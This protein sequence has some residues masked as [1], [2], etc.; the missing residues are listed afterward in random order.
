[1]FYVRQQRSGNRPSGSRHSFHLYLMVAS[2]SIFTLIASLF[3]SSA[4]AFAA[5]VALASGAPA[6]QARQTSH[7]QQKPKLSQTPELLASDGAANDQFAA[8]LNLS[9]NGKVGIIGAPFHQVGNNASAG[10]AY[11]YVRNDNGTWSQVAELTASDGAADD[12]FGTS[13]SLSSD[14]S[15]AIVGAPNHQVGNN[16]GAG[17]AYVYTHSGNT[18]TQ[19]AILTATNNAAG[20]AL[21]TGSSLSPDGNTALVGADGRDNGAG[22]AYIF[23]KGT[24]GSWSQISLLTASDSVAN[25]QLGFSA[26]LSG[27][28]STALIGAAATLTTSTTSGAAYIFTKGTSGWSASQTQTA[29]VS[30]S[31][32]ATGD[33]FGFTVS[34]SFNGGVAMVGAIDHQVGNNA[35]AGEAYV[36]TRGTSSNSYSQSAILRSSDQA[37]GDQF[38]YSVSLT[39]DGN[40]ALIGAQGHMVNGNATAGSAYVFKYSN[41]TWNQF[42]EITVY[43]PGTGDNFGNTDGISSDGNYA[44]VG[45]PVHMVGN[46]AAQGDA[47][48]FAL[49]QPTNELIAPDNGAGDQLGAALNLSAD[50]KVAIAGAPFHQ[51]GNNAGAGAAYIYV[52]NSTG[53]FQAAELTAPDGAA[54]DQFGTSVSL[55]GDGST[56]I[57]GA[58][59]H[60]IGSNAGAGATYVFSRGSGNVWTQ[61]A[62]LTASGGQA[63]DGLGIGGSIS[64]DGNTTIVGAAG[65]A[66]NAGAAYVF[67]RSN[68]TWHQIALL[69]AA[70]SIPNNQLGFSV[71]LSGD[72][73]TVIIGASATMT[74][75]TTPGAAYIFTKSGTNS[76]NA[77]ETAMLNPSDGATG[78][79]FGFTVS[80]SFNG[81]VA[82]VGAI[83][84]QV[85][86]NATAGEAYVYTRGSNN[87]YS[88]SAILHS[89]DQ[90]AGDQFGYAVSLS[91]DGNTALIGAQGH[92]VN[93]KANAGSGYIFRY[94]GS[95]W[96]QT[97]ELTGYDEGADDNFGNTASLSSDG[98]TGVIGAPVHMVGNNAGA[99][100]VYTFSFNPTYT[101]NLPLLANNATTAV[102]KTTTYV[103]FQNLSSAVAANISVQYYDPTTGTAVATPDSFQIPAKGQTAPTLSIGTGKSYGGIVTSDQPLNLVV[104]EGL[105]SGGS[106]YNVSPATASTL[107]SPL[108]YNG[109]YGFTTSF[110]VFNAGNTASTGTIQFYDEDGNLV[111]AATQNFNIPAHASQTF[112]QAGTNSGL[113]ATTSYW[114]KITSSNS[115][116]KLAG[117]IIEFGPSNFVA[118]FNAIVPSQVSGNLYAPATFNGNFGFV[119]GM[120]IANPN[121]ATTIGNIVYY[122]KDGNQLFSEPFSILANGSIGVY[123]PGVTN[124]PKNVTSA[125]V[126]ANQPLIMT[127]NERGSGTISG[128]YV[129]LAN[130][131]TSVP[132]PVLANGAFGF[133]TGTTILNTSNS[134]AHLTFTYLTQAGSQIGTTQTVTLNAHASYQVFQGDPAQNLGSNYFGTALLSSDQPLLVTTNALNT[135]NGLFYTYT[136]PSN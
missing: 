86:N 65:R 37:A 7:N 136:E 72:G 24:S 43:D 89:N 73:S 122:D 131:S 108:A 50:G 16:A 87:S 116:D 96:N 35:T 133:T 6:Q 80:L 56:A 66:N 26:S 71:N 55:S 21:G 54:D 107:Y 78:D 23:T 36:Y 75:S 109:E 74:T 10:S 27:D 119:T 47:Y 49:N 84:H 17:A 95:T 33:Q 132:L 92:I 52:K 127:V 57:V 129:G 126:V 34:L 15:I 42:T 44:L 124:L 60:Q 118:T 90:A 12:Q 70:T 11:I 13:V 104:A 46:N 110:V 125:A 98:S 22:A 20:D 82:M 77:H 113:N 97:A 41:G 40:T 115:T 121:T 30:P 25:N 88:Q 48:G 99:G 85:G 103:T 93:S 28:G 68:G 53:W 31:D 69:T 58:P 62:V 102:G 29:K 106:A 61:T 105:Q 51:V 81:S 130:G 135:S 76:W 91:S 19:T 101:Y 39:S 114:A 9:G 100:A 83:D 59:N 79:Q 45:A 2:L 111:S 4:S 18:W 94:T 63:G 134:S 128:T 1:M 32:G 64:L 120:A 8:A 112:N 123:Q 67:T 3:S 117:Q 5:S 14:G 38:G